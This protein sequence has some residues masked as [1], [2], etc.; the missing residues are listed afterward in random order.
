MITEDPIKALHSEI[1]SSG[2]N[3]AQTAYRVLEEMIV[4]LALV[5]FFPQ[6]ATWLPKAIG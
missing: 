4:T 1:E 2:Q 6:I 5:F 3:Q